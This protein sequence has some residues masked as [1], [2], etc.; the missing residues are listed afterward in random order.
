MQ[1]GFVCV[2]GRPIGSGRLA[3]WCE[4]AEKVVGQIAGFPSPIP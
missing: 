1:V 4:A 3:K 2:A